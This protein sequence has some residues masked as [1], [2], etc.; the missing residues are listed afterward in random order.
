M[1]LP[2]SVR[3]QSSAPRAVVWERLSPK[4]KMLAYHLVQ[5]ANAGR[6]LLFYQTHR[7]SLAVKHLLET[8]FSEDHAAETK[9]LLGDKGYA[10]LM[11]YAA[12]FLDQGGP[13][14]PSNR[15]YVLRQVTPAQIGCARRPNGRAPRFDRPPG[16]SAPAH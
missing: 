4:E 2:K 3:V 13:Y 8:A 14:T 16:D 5:A 6:D 1:P 11:I 12:K 9:S 10:E 15:K 7:H